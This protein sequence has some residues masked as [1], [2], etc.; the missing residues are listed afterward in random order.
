MEEHPERQHYTE[1]LP[2]FISEYGGI[3]WD[4]ACENKDAWGYGEAPKTEAEFI[5][6]YRGLTE[7]LLKHPY[8]MG[9]C[10]TQLYD[11]EQE[12]N[13]LYDYDRKPKFNPDIFYEINSRRA[14]IED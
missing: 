8:I 14:A 13:G 6:R 10:Y 1:G 9:F 3:K 7:C 2:L 11:I 12:T 5:E 4:T